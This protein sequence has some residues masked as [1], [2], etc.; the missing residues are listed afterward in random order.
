MFVCHTDFDKAR[1]MRSLAFWRSLIYKPK[2]GQRWLRMN[3][4]GP[5]AASSA[6]TILNLIRVQTIDIL[7]TK[8]LSQCLS[9]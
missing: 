3:L 6:V 1:Q 7:I 8:F 5:S 2:I 4:H 9:V